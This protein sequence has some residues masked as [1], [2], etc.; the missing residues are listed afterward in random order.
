MTV[1]FLLLQAAQRPKRCARQKN[2]I[3]IAAR[4][5]PDY[6]FLSVFFPFAVLTVD[7]DNRF[8]RTV[9]CCGIAPALSH[10]ARYRK[11]FI[12]YF[13]YPSAALS[14]ACIKRVR[15]SLRVSKHKGYLI[16]CIYMYQFFVACWLLGRFIIII[17]ITVM[18]IVID[19]IRFYESSEKA[20][21]EKAT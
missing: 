2:W 20:L 9:F 11:I 14:R 21:A 10:R 13:W 16:I 4:F 15:N 8:R 3:V 12:A 5:G 1:L 18:I 19:G 6:T 17:M 7:W